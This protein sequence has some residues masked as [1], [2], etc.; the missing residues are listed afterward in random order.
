MPYFK[1]I[2]YLVVS[3]D[4]NRTVSCSNDYNVPLWY[5][6]SGEGIVVPMRGHAESVT[7]VAKVN[8]INIETVCG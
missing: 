2:N 1:K 3:E 5:G 6:F 8:E 7:C 4:V